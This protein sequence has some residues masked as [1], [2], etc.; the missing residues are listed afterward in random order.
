MMGIKEKKLIDNCDQCILSSL[1]WQTSVVDKTQSCSLQDVLLKV[2]FQK[3]MTS[4]GGTS[5]LKD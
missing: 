2:S 1:Y 5:H 4:C 3:E